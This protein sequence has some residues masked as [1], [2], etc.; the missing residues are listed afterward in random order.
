MVGSR[1]LTSGSMSLLIIVGS[2]KVNV[3]MCLKFTPFLRVA[4]LPPYLIPAYF[5][6][7]PVSLIKQLTYA[8]AARRLNHWCI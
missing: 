6:E 4:V 8:N 7:P 3:G 2:A 1:A 5:V